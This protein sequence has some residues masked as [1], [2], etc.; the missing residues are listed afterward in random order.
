MWWNGVMVYAYVNI[1]I[2]VVL[3]IMLKKKEIN[4]NTI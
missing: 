3:K 1:N 2:Y 4:W